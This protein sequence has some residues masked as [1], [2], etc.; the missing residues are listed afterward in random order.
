MYNTPAIDTHHLP[1][2]S[3]ITTATSPIAQYG[4]LEPIPSLSHGGHKLSSDQLS[5]DSNSSDK[6]PYGL[7]PS[8]ATG[9]GKTRDRSTFKGVLDKFVGSFSGK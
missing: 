5:D 6:E 9:F 8:N 1:P 4:S 3:D 2:S 7:S